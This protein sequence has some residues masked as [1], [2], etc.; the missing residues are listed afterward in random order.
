MATF[1]CVIF[2]A[3]GSASPV[4]ASVISSSSVRQVVIELCGSS[5]WKSRRYC[6]VWHRSTASKVSRLLRKEMCANMQC[7]T[8]SESRYQTCFRRSGDSVD[9][10]VVKL[11]FVV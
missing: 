7:N 11:G 5:C 8:F 10:V 3:Q 9:C 2:G 4:F 1:R 6:W